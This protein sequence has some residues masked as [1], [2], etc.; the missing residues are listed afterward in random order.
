MRTKSIEKYNKCMTLYLS[1]LDGL[2]DVWNFYFDNQNS[3]PMLTGSELGY[4]E[5]GYQSSS[6]NKPKV[7][8]NREQRK[9]IIDKTENEIDSGKMKDLECRAWNLIVIVDKPYKKLSSFLE[10]SG[11][12]YIIE[13]SGVYIW[14]YCQKDFGKLV[15]YEYSSCRYLLYL[16]RNC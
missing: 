8:L 14:D 1:L 6:N 12:V 13:S 10:E 16:I 5:S 7:E 2:M 15:G 4:I 3:V 9:A 11:V